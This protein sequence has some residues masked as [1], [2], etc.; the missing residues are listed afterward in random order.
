MKCKKCGSDM[1]IDEWNGWVWYCAV[2]DI[3]YR[4]ATNKEIEDQEKGL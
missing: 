2:C 1:I 4:P 3:V